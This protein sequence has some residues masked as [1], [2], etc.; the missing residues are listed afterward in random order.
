M[1]SGLSV[2]TPQRIRGSL[3]RLRW[4]DLLW[5]GKLH[6]PGPPSTENKR[7]ELFSVWAAYSSA[8]GTVW[9]LQFDLE[10]IQPII[11]SPLV[12]SLFF[13]ISSLPADN[14]CALSFFPLCVGFIVGLSLVF[15][16]TTAHNHSSFLKRPTSEIHHCCSLLCLPPL[17][18]FSLIST[19]IMGQNHPPSPVCVRVCTPLMCVM[20]DNDHEMSDYQPKHYTQPA[21]GLHLCVFTADVCCCQFSVCV[22]ASRCVTLSLSSGR[23]AEPADLWVCLSRQG[24][25]NNTK[26][27]K[28]RWSTENGQDFLVSLSQIW[29]FTSFLLYLIVNCTSLQLKII[30][31]L[32]AHD[33]IFPLNNQTLDI[34]HVVVATFRHKVK[35]NLLYRK[36]NDWKES[37]TDKT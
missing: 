37:I 19:Q 13:F 6:P 35:L 36:N 14:L 10:A 21:P 33:C 28:I 16:A 24:K 2:L 34:I 26:A 31:A 25:K 30:Q 18:H 15:P 9:L 17:C 12:L 20:T 4:S 7:Y 1:W 11:L 27:E 8:A 29:G 32:R 23:F 22:W 3:V 5:R